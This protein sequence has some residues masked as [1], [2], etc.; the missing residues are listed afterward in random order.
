MTVLCCPF[1]SVSITKSYCVTQSI[2]HYTTL[3]LLLLTVILRLC[4]QYELAVGLQ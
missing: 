4:M 2:L 1:L 3:L